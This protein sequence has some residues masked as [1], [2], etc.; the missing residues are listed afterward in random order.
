MNFFYLIFGIP[1]LS[2][3]IVAFK[4][5]NE[6]SNKLDNITQLIL[7]EQ[8]PEPK[9]G[10]QLQKTTPLQCSK[11]NEIYPI[12]IHIRNNLVNNLCIIF[13]I[14][15]IIYLIFMVMVKIQNLE[16]EKLSIYIMFI[17][18]ITFFSFILYNNS[19]NNKNGDISDLTEL[20]IPKDPKD[21][22]DKKDGKFKNKLYT[23]N[24]Q[25]IS[26]LEEQASN[27]NNYYKQVY[28]TEIG[29]TVFSLLLLIKYEDISEKLNEIFSF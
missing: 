20:L 22:K 25:N 5:Y 13:I 19:L 6:L 21:T 14:P 9:E 1:L 10:Q 11:I 18:K 12:L 28:Y 23:D 7:S 15:I 26:R 8:P 29:L 16:E 3:M 24:K 2:Y 27:I 17:I 4:D